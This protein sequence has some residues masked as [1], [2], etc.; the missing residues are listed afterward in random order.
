MR[1]ILKSKA[2][3]RR[4]RSILIDRSTLFD[5]SK[6]KWKKNS[7][8]TPLAQEIAAQIIARGPISV[9]EYMKQCLTHPTHGYYTNREHVFGTKGDFT[10]A[11]EISQLFGEAVAVWV[12]MTWQAM[13]SPEKFQLV[14]LGPGNGTLANDMIRTF[15]KFP[16]LANAIEYNFVEISDKMQLKQSEMI[17]NNKINH[18]TMIERCSWHSRLG[19]VEKKDGCPNIIIGQEILDALYIHRFTYTKNGWREILVDIEENSNAEF[20]F[21][22]VTSP[23]ETPASSM[24]LSKH[25][26][27]KEKRVKDFGIGSTIEVGASACALVQDCATRI[28]ELGGAALFIDYGDDFA[29]TDSFRGIS[30]HKFCSPLFKPGEIDLTA[31]VDFAA[32]RRAI[33]HHDNIVIRSVETQN[34]F[35][36]SM[37]IAERFE[38]LYQNRETEKEKEMLMQEYERL[39][40]DKEMGELFKI[41]TF[42]CMNTTSSK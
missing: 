21:R 8:S 20:E 6:I 38:M 7:Y 36:K 24:L 23:G 29:S 14:E 28:S 27:E 37:G 17:R 3:T 11:P 32:L 4:F 25:D 42:S 34:Y 1:S 9:S 12:I 39:M 18:Q 5:P 15:D 30:K 26:N 16:P 22:F 2:D 13:G 41:F 40:S 10:T 19:E 31:D 35:L 33:S